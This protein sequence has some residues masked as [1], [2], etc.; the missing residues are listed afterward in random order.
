[1]DTRV[2][3]LET[4]Y[5]TMSRDKLK[6]E[7]KSY[8]FDFVNK[9]TVDGAILDYGQ[10]DDNFVHKYR[11]LQVPEACR[12]LLLQ[13]HVNQDYNVCLYF[14][15]TAN[16]VLCF[17]LDNNYKD[18][19]TEVIQ[20]MNLAVQYLQQHLRRYGME[21]LVLK[22]GRG[23][24]L[25]CRFN[26]PIENRQLYGFMVRMAAKTW[27]SLHMS[28]H[29]YHTIKFNMGPNPNVVNVVSLRLFGSRHVK[30]GVFS[31]V[32]TQ[33]GILN[34]AASWRYFEDYMLNK[35]ISKEQFSLVCT[36]LAGEIPL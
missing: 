21:A 3:L 6:L 1:M 7:S 19:N 32:Q 5:A 13:G 25:W 20:E 23:Y 12:S 18:R 26:E 8:G 30:T 33:D 9:L 10:L 34:E 36:E 17:N 29:D 2:I 31:H 28:N 22:S 15:K 16:N 24:H 11:L 35:T 14:H 27:A 4:F